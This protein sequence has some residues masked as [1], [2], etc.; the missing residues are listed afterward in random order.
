MRKT[1]ITL[2]SKVDSLIQ[3]FKELILTSVDADNINDAN[4]IGL[5]PLL[6]IIEFNWLEP[7]DEQTI[8]KLELIDYV[9]S[10]GAKIDL[11]DLVP[12]FSALHYAASQH[13]FILVKHLLSK[14]ANIEAL[15]C[16]KDTPLHRVI[17]SG[18]EGDTENQ[19]KTVEI[20]LQ[21]GANINAVNTIGFSPLAY[22][23]R[24]ENPMLYYLL[25]DYGK[26]EKPSEN[27]I[28]FSNLLSQFSHLFRREVIY[29]AEIHIVGE[30]HYGVKNILFKKKLLELARTGKNKFFLGLEGH[31][32]K[33]F[34]KTKEF[35]CSGIE[36]Q[37]ITL[38]AT[39]IAT[40][41]WYN[42]KQPHTEDLQNR[43]SE[44]YIKGF[45]S[46]CRII[47]FMEYDKIMSHDLFEVTQASDCELFFKN[48][49]GT[50]L[51]RYAYGDSSES[52]KRE[53]FFENKAYILNDIETFSKVLKTAGLILQGLIKKHCPH[54]ANHPALSDETLNEVF[55]KKHFFEV[56]AETNELILLFLLDLKNK[57]WKT[58]IDFIN[59]YALNKR[60]P[61]IFI[62]GESHI[63]GL[64]EL[65]G[66]SQGKFSINY[67]S[68]HDFETSRLRAFLDE[69][70]PNHDL[71]NYST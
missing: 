46:L 68:Q 56:N 27:E 61:T 22:A 48:M 19:Q 20:L 51:L 12:R 50:D 40:Y 58:N 59:E 32:F 15:N 3:K 60:L 24:H 16:F 17:N 14:G 71:K 6:E 30:N 65:L 33:D 34:D 37:L 5:T 54:L 11:P 41:I 55:S 28:K 45:L 36:T 53:W 23:K 21:N 31:L 70:E 69:S 18:F 62:V 25:L 1:E 66:S 67:Y 57:D 26:A 42:P 13:D 63:S 4:E 9:L 7:S 38:Y 47:L 8:I 2:I 35:N 39:C 10:L 52:I 64:K 49:P 43:A 29:A 44:F